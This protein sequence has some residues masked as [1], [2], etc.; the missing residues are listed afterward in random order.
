MKPTIDAVSSANT[1]LGVV[2]LSRSYRS[3]PCLN[4]QRSVIR[5]NGVAECPALQLVERCADIFQELAI[6]AFQFTGRCHDCDLRRNTIGYRA[7]MAFTGT[8]RFL[9]SLPLVLDIDGHSAPFDN[10]PGWIGYRTGTKEK[11]PILPVEAAYAH[12]HV[13]PL[14]GGKNCSPAV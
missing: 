4:R 10:P 3:L 13:T 9:S 12:L 8:Q 6:D 7:K 5:V 11:L 1:V 2:W 14:A